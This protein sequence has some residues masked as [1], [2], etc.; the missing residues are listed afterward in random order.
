[1]GVVINYNNEDLTIPVEHA[2]AM[3][4]VLAKDTSAKAAAGVNLADG[5]I[6][7]PLRASVCGFVYADFVFLMALV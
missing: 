2:L 7:K 3:V 5:V 6:G 1:M 4:L